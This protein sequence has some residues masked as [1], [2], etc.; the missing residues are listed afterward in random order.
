MP[1]VI[2]VHATDPD[3][4]FAPTAASD[5]AVIDVAARALLSTSPGGRYDY[6]SGSSMAAARVAGLAALLCQEHSSATSR[7]FRSELDR[8]VAELGARRDGTDRIVTRAPGTS[9]SAPPKGILPQ[10]IPSPSHV[11]T[12]RLKGT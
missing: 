2:A 3:G 7:D 5:H 8:R 12:A 11:E 9:A 6:F 1:G 10:S 4:A